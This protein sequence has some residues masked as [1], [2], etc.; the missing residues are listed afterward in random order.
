M[1]LIF[2]II[3]LI[4]NIS[5]FGQKIDVFG[6]INNNRFH[7][8]VDRGHFVSSYENDFGF[9][10][11]A[12]LDSIIMGWHRLRLMLQIEKYGSSMTV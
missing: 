4:I 1:K 11:G 6:G 7:D 5:L 3:V 8:Y 9:S 10:V 2:T 12:G